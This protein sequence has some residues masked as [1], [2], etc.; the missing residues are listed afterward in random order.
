[1]D[2]HLVHRVYLREARDDD[3][4]DAGEISY[5]IN[6]AETRASEKSLDRFSLSRSDFHH[7]GTAAIEARAAP[8]GD[9]AKEVERVAAGRERDVRLVE[10][11]LGLKSLNVILGDIWRVGNNKVEARIVI[12]KEIGLDKVDTIRASI[13]HRITSCNFKCRL[14]YVGGFDL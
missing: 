10:A 4:F 7:H 8:R 6:F 9:T 2:D 12:G 14:R 11:N 1:M 3:S 13:A 5:R